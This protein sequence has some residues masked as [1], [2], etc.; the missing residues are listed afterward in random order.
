MKKVLG[1]IFI[2]LGL[3]LTLVLIVSISKL[4]SPIPMAFSGKVNQIAYL[5]GRLFPLVLCIGLIYLLFRYG[6]KLLRKPK[7]SHSDMLDDHLKQNQPD[8]S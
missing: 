7:P 6:F 1:V 4:V 8:K 5:L 2:L 3:F